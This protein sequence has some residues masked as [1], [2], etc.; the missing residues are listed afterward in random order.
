M[1]DF[2]H[3]GRYIVHDGDGSDVVKTVCEITSR[4]KSW[5]G[6]YSTFQQVVW[7]V[8]QRYCTLRATACVGSWTLPVQRQ[9]DAARQGSR[10][11]MNYHR[12]WNDWFRMIPMI[13]HLVVWGHVYYA[14]SAPNIVAAFARMVEETV[15]VVANNR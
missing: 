9:G 4:K 3:G 2:I 13:Q 12:H 10:I 7:R 15:S 11:I 6:R 5:V 8:H 1:T 14:N